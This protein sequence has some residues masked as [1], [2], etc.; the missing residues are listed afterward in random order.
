MNP[1]EI[2]CPNIDCPARGQIGKGNIGIQSRKEKRFVCHVCQRTFTTRKST[3]FYRLHSDPQLVLLVIA[4]L[5]YGCPRQAIVHA[6]HLDERTVR[7]WWLRAGQHCEAVHDYLLG[8]CQLDLQQVQADEIKVRTQRG[9]FWM[10]LALTVPTRLWLGGAVSAHR[11]AA[12]I[13]TVANQVRAMA[14]CRPLL[15]AVDGWWS[16]ITAFRRAFRTPL[17][18]RPGE[19]GRQLLIPWPNIA[20]VQ[21]IKP[22]SDEVWQIQRRIVQGGVQMIEHLIQR[23]QGGGVINT[24]YIERLNAT[25]RQRLDNLTR[26]T[27][28]LARHPETLTAGMYLLGCVYNFCDWHQSLRLRLCVGRYGFHWVQRTPALAAR[29]TDH[30]WSLE[31]LMIFKVPLPA[32]KP[33]LGRGRPSNE[34]RRLMD[35][36]VQ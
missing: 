25:F 22:R 29:L 17:P 13:Q 6:F 36:W 32:W 12:L 19:G 14:L 23:T 1:Q 2:F 30:R 8:H 18:R 3:L 33:Q 21:V 24:A 35:R 27:R 4:L 26:H 28:R 9:S 31:E 11:D 15:L 16:Y 5:V 34:F 7:Q 10:A 20:I